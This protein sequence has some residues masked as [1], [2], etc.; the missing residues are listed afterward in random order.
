MMTA[1]RFRYA[2]NF[3]SLTRAEQDLLPEIG[4]TQRSA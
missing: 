3:R 2:D 4:I 1:T